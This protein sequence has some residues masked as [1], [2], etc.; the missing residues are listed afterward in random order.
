M[1]MAAAEMSP[2]VPRMV[3]KAIQNLSRFQKSRLSI[4]GF[5][6]I[7]SGAATQNN[8]DSVYGHLRAGGQTRRADVG[9]RGS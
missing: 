8:D 4:P 5:E 2:A 9:R 6:R 1:F 3:M 7:C